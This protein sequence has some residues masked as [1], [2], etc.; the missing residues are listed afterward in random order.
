MDGT[1][2]QHI[3]TW[4]WA[5]RVIRKKKTEQNWVSDAHVEVAGH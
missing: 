4:W 3:F 2:I 5:G 1:G